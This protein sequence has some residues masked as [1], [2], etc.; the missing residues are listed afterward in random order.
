LVTRGWFKHADI[1]KMHAYKDAIGIPAGQVASVWVLYP[2]TEF[3]FFA[4]D[5][6]KI[7]RAI[8]RTRTQWAI[9]KPRGTSCARRESAAKLEAPG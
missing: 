4:E 9:M 6:T 3:R 1:L 7:T 5:G 8:V 2:G